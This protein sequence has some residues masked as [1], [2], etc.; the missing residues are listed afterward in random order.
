MGLLVS[1]AVA[2]TC[3]FQRH[4]EGIINTLQLLETS[5]RVLKQT[6][7]SKNQV[8]NEKVVISE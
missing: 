4:N 6:S 7:T 1:A 8:G 3:I 5:D 2:L